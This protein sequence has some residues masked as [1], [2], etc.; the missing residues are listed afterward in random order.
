MRMWVFGVKLGVI[1]TQIG[2]HLRSNWG[3]LNTNWG[4]FGVKWGVIWGE[5]GSNKGSLQL[6]LDKHLSSNIGV[7]S[8]T[9][10]FFE[11]GNFKWPIKEHPIDYLLHYIAVLF[12]LISRLEPYQASKQQK[13]IPRCRKKH[14]KRAES[15]SIRMLAILHGPDTFV[16]Y[17][18]HLQAPSKSI[19]HQKERIIWKIT[20]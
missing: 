19:N 4:I 15:H 6:K 12:P 20:K 16:L 11:S 13:R 9:E 17:D 10:I 1:D 3:N 7:Y 14:L 5:T 18:L 2:Y 8:M